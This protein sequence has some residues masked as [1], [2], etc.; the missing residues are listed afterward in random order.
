MPVEKFGI[1]IEHMFGR[2]CNYDRIIREFNT[3]G[4]AI[5]DGR[6]SH[7]GSSSTAWT[8]KRDGS[9]NNGGELVSPPLDFNDPEKRGQ[10]DRAV[11]CLQRAGALP[12]KRAGIHVH[13]GCQDLNAIQIAAVCRFFYKFEDVLYRIASSGWE[14]IRPGALYRGRSSYAK[15]LQADVIKRMT[16]VRNM[17]NLRDAWQGG[18][19]DAIFGT[20]RYHAVNLESWWLRG[21]IEFRLF[22]SSL[23]PDRI[24]AYIAICAAIIRDARNGKRTGRSTAKNF[25]LGT[26]LAAGEPTHCRTCG[27]PRPCADHWYQHPALVRFQQVIRYEAGLSKED[28]KKVLMCWNDSRPQAAVNPAVNDDDFDDDEDED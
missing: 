17:E 5:V 11:R 28:W 26:M 13:I 18:E 2:G 25:P 8:I 6:H 10:V 16:K 23:N 22:N 20:R 12:D 19:T 3:E 7:A 9:I 4:L 24:Q 14:T 21:T 1:E 27:K 15:P